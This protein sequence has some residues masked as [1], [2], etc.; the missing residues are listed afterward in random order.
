MLYACF[1]REGATFLLLGDHKSFDDSS[2][3]R[4]A[5][6][7]RGG[8][9]VQTPYSDQERRQLHRHGKSTIEVVDGQVYVGTGLSTDGT[10]KVD[11]AGHLLR[12]V[13]WLDPYLN[14]PE[15]WRQALP[16]H[17]LAPDAD[18]AWAMIGGDLAIADMKANT[19]VA[20]APKC[21][22]RR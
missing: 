8:G 14:D 1:E 2:L 6:A 10:S 15:W 12:T 13:R 9:T 16:G 4:T 22:W 3:A 21:Q 5:A 7:W 19:V 17:T 18:L 20:A 11:W